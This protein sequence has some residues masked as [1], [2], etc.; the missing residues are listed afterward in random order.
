M[1]VATQAVSAF[2]QLFTQM[3]EA[4]GDAKGLSKAVSGNQIKVQVK[5]STPHF[6]VSD[7]YFFVPAY[8]TAE[9]VAQFRTRS[10]NISIEALA[11]KIIQIQK[12]NLEM[13]R[14]DSN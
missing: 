12:W 8:F 10:P 9:A 6:L 7:G 2:K 4:G 5:E 14:V 13:R 1:A 11:G 3:I